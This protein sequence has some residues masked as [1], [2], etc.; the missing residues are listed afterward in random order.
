MSVKTIFFDFN[1]TIADT[2]DAA[3]HIYTRLKKEFKLTD[4]NPTELVAL[5]SR[6][7]FYYAWKLGMRPWNFSKIKKESA[8]IVSSLITNAKPFIELKDTLRSLAEKEVKLF[9]ISSNA[10]DDIYEFLKRHEL[11]YFLEIYDNV[12]L[13]K[14]HRTIQKVLTEHHLTAQEVLFIGDEMR[15]YEA[16]KK[17]HVPFV[18]AKWGHIGDKGL[19]F[20]EPVLVKNSPHEILDLLDRK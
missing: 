16:S 18:F 2:G 15:D 3:I 4:L 1:G 12:T 10:Y 19:L 14:K 6:S 9:I 11:D 5:K 17:A 8:I 20:N 7:L 13:N